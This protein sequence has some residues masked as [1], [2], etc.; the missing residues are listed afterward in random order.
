[1]FAYRAGKNVNIFRGR[2]LKS[3]KIATVPKEAVEGTI[4]LED[5]P[6]PGFGIYNPKDAT[7]LGHLIRSAHAFAIP[8]VFQIGGDASWHNIK[9]DTTKAIRWLV[10]G[11][12]DSLEHL[13]QEFSHIPI[14]GIEIDPN[15]RGITEFKPPR[16]ALYLLGREDE[17]LPEEI[18]KRLDMLVQIP[19]VVP[20]NVGVTSAIVM[21]HWCLKNGFP[22][23]RAKGRGEQQQEG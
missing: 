2:P 3:R 23:W 1:M 4:P 10:C 16:E 13:K 20:L 19:T 21:F 12:Y 18:L 17:G 14:I 6:L 5:A 15:A 9:T 7:N 8:F 22:M 11:E